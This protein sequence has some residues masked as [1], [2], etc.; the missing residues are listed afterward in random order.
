MKQ[1]T[2]FKHKESIIAYEGTM[3][4]VDEYRKLLEPS[5]KLEKTPNNIQIEKMCD[6]CHKPGHLKE[7]CHWN[8]K[9]LNNKLNNKKKVSMNKISP[10][11]GRRMSGNHGKQGN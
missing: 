8:P 9:T 10:H 11:V 2:L 4:N 7:H 1:N 3:E 6:F 5:K